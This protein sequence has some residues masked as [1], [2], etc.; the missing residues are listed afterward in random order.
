MGPTSQIALLRI[1]VSV[2]GLLN[3]RR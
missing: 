2:A 3:I 1:A